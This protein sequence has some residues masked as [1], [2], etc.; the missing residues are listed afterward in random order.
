MRHIL[1]IILISFIA[2]IASLS[3]QEEVPTSE[4]TKIL[5]EVYLLDGD[6]FKGE[7]ISYIPNDYLEIATTMGVTLKLSLDKVKKVKQGQV[8]IEM[9]T[10][11][12]YNF[13]ESRLYFFAGLNYLRNN[14]TKGYSF[15]IGGIKQFSRLMGIGLEASIDQYENGR[16][17][18]FLPVSALYRAYLK[19]S[20]FSPFVQINAGYGFVNKDE[21]DGTFN[22]DGGLMLNPKFGLR[23]NAGD[24]AI[25][26]S[27]I[28]IK[29][30]KAYFERGNPENLFQESLIYKRIQIGV[31]VLF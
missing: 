30:Q 10:Q 5:D 2:T 22:A 4:Q 9:R 29:Y 23:M 24:G 7:I 1:T 11:A 15:N 16:A 21:D 19:R 18:W 17:E 3:A 31:E 20:N 12:P 13:Y 27:H 28:G 6:I 8:N 25:I 26:T 14:S